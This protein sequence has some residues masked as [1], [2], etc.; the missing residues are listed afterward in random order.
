MFSYNYPVLINS[1]S[2][3]CD[4]QSAKGF[5]VTFAVFMKATFPDLLPV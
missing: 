4:T 5:G 1:S 2:A 3:Y